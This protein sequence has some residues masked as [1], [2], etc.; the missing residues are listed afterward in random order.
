MKL[1]IVSQDFPPAVGG[2]QTYAWELSRR[3]AR[4]SRLSILV[5][6]ADGALPIDR[7]LPARVDRIGIRPDLLPI[8]LLPT[9]PFRAR[10]ERFDVSLHAQWQTAGAALLSRAMTGYPQRIVVAAHGRELLFNPFPWASA[11]AYD[12]IRRRVLRSVDLLLPVSRY[13]AELLVSAGV[14][15][16][17][18]RTVH[19][20]TDPDVFRPVDPSALRRS[21]GTEGRRILLT[22]TRLVG[23]KGVDT[24]LDA[25]PRVLERNPT[26][27]YLVVG[28][29]PERQSLEYQARRLGSQ[30]DVRFLGRVPYAELPAYYSLAD[31]AV[32][33]SRNEPPDVEGFGIVFL[34]ANACGCA[35]IGAASGG[36]PDAVLDG[37]TG[38]LVPPADPTALAD[39]ITR[40]LADD[41]LRERLGSTG[42]KRVLAEATWQH[43]ADAVYAALAVAQ[44]GPVGFR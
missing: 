20:G 2:I 26:V 25:L 8:A 38:L 12:T 6:A 14:D 15:H 43:A 41:S 32:M 44:A 35:V 17:R 18:I 34:E 21:L 30:A 10:S 33:P 36:I 16:R 13:T 28:D 31:V 29:G 39:A 9:L 5:P 7:D 11:R 23:R 40:I 27:T 19:N 42:R 22:V 3:L 4:R 24:V 37:E 1:L